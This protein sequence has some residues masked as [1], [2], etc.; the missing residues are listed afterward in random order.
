[1]PA[2]RES[3]IIVLHLTK[4]G[5]RSQVVQALDAERGRTGFFL[6][7]TG[8]G[9][10]PQGQYHPL[11]ILDIS[12]ASG[13]GSLEY[14]RE[15]ESPY[16][17][18]NLRTDPYKSAIALFISELLYRCLLDGAMDPQMFAFLEQQILSL[19]GASG[20]IAN[21]HL[22][23]L[24]DFCRELGFQP[25]DNYAPESPLF[26]PY[27]AEFTGIDTLA[28][29]FGP[30]E[31]L[32]LHSLLSLERGEAMQLKMSRQLRGAFAQKMVEY[33]SYHLSQNL[34]IRS[35]KVLHG[36]FS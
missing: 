18:T 21:F 10:G 19:E 8:K 27:S 11:S 20:S 16:S 32:L 12:A 23:F 24:V 29:T 7:G 6:R 30:E 2:E 9:R 15:A 31:S 28:E 4:Y 34:N 35:L 33:L 25:K 1:M 22:C 36:L 14:I 26:V 3:R 17:L 13:F 5:D